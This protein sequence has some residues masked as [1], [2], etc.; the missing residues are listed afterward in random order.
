ME[1]YG[2]TDQ[3]DPVTVKDQRLSMMSDAQLD[4]AAFSHVYDFYNECMDKP[5][6]LANTHWGDEGIRTLMLQH[7]FE[8]HCMIHKHSCFK[9]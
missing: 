6:H 8:Y 7:R 2:I 3:N 5:I 4:A 9:K 1:S